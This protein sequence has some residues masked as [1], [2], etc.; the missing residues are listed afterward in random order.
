MVMLYSLWEDAEL[1]LAQYPP[2]W[3]LPVPKGWMLFFTPTLWHAVWRLLDHK[4][5]R[6]SITYRGYLPTRVWLGGD[7][8][9][10]TPDAF[11]LDLTGGIQGG[12]LDDGSVVCVPPRL[13]HQAP[14][15]EYEF[16]LATNVLRESRDCPGPRRAW[17]MGHIFSFHKREV[18]GY[19][20]FPDEMQESVN[21]TTRSP[22]FR[23]CPF[24]VVQCIHNWYPGDDTEWWSLAPKA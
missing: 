10:N 21:T 24:F 5:T 2:Y 6:G 22:I 9:V 18:V 19:M 15:L 3:Q 4:S 20:P 11:R 23:S 8:P 7:Y 12:S 14:H 13:H 17:Q 1:W 16:R